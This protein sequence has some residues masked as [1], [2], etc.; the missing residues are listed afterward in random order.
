MSLDD[1]TRASLRL[2]RNTFALFL[3]RV[4]WLWP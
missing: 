2:L 4:S 3:L 1:E